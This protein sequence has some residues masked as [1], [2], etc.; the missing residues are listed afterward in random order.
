MCDLSKEVVALIDGEL[1]ADETRQLERHLQ[2]CDECR[3]RAEEYRRAG[4]AFEAYCDA[5]CEALTESKP[6]F[7]L[8]HWLPAISAATAM[9][10]VAAV[11]LL[12]TPRTRV[13]RLVIRAPAPPLHIALYSLPARTPGEEAA[14]K[15]HRREAT[16]LPNGL[17]HRRRF[18]SARSS[19]GFSRSSE[20]QQTARSLAQTRSEEADSS[21]GAPAVQV[22]IPAD[23][24]FPPGAV[25][26]GIS[27][28]A[29]IAI[30]PDAS[31]QR[32][33]LRPRLA[34]FERSMT[35]P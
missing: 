21:F 33:S 13:P 6:R 17:H 2:T 30:E 34:Q 19:A 14:M 22:A 9:A 5:Y 1:S 31:A 4:R 3:G 24:L 18:G 11:L 35:G 32:I 8:I 23:S 7:G 29:D 25:P 15:R 28:T 20:D 16:G 27:F 26:P 12:F 10:A